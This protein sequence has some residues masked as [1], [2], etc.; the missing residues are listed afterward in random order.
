M[1]SGN[2]PTPIKEVIQVRKSERIV[3][4]EER[5]RNGRQKILV[6]GCEREKGR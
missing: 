1:V 2:P 5:E 3:K 4:L 6:R